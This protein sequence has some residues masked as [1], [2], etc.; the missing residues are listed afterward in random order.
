MAPGHMLLVTFGFPPTR[1]ETPWLPSVAVTEAKHHS[2]HQPPTS[3]TMTTSSS[4]PF[5]R[6]NSGYVLSLSFRASPICDVGPWSG[7]TRVAS[8]ADPPNNVGPSPPPPSVGRLSSA[9]VR[10]SEYHIGGNSCTAF[11]ADPC[12]SP[13]QDP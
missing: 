1:S 9:A 11:P 4:L 5:P 8:H 3:P 2:D 13:A 12:A 10:F 7:E 6:Y